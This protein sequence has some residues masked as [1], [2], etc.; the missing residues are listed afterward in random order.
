MDFVDK[1]LNRIDGEPELKG[2]AHAL[3]CF[4]RAETG[5]RMCKLALE[6]VLSKTVKNI[7]HFVV[8]RPQHAGVDGG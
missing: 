8:L 1:L 4:T 2:T 7:D 5:K 6:T 3:V